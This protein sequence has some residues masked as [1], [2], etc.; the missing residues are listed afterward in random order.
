MHA[1][2]ETIINLKNNNLYIDFFFLQKKAP[3]NSLK[4]VLMENEEAKVWS[5]AKERGLSNRMHKQKLHANACWFT[6][7]KLSDQI[8]FFEYVL[9]HRHF[10]TN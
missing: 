10:K 3:F 5:C 8:H 7:L 9:V 2:R 1:K 6:K 4:S